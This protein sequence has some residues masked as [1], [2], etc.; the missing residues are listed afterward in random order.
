MLTQ[1]PLIKDGDLVLDDAGQLESAPDIVT[2]CTVSVGAYHCMYDSAINSGLIPFLEGIPI[3]GRNNQAIVNIVK[4]AFQPLISQNL[5][6]NLTIGVV[7]QT[8]SY[9]T[10]KIKAIDPQQN[11]VSLSWSNA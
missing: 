4:A 2:Q 7:V 3:G 11:P 8:L 10:I 1:S 6:S 5:L 9:I